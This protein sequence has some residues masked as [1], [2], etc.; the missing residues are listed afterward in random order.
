MKISIILTANHIPDKTT[1]HKVTGDNYYTLQKGLDIYD[2]NGKKIFIEVKE[3]YLIGIP[4]GTITQIQEDKK[5][6]IDFDSV[7]ELE[8]F[9]EIHFNVCQ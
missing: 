6:R 8:Y 5:L 3:N 7:E 4:N 1:V 2:K 9:I